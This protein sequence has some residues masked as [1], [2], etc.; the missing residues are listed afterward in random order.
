MPRRYKFTYSGLLLTALLLLI[1][2][3]SYLFSALK[4][5]EQ[6]L[7][8][9]E[10]ILN[11]V[12]SL[13]SG[14]AS[15]PDQE[16][17]DRTNELAKLA[18]E[19][20]ILR[21]AIVLSSVIGLRLAFEYF[22][23]SRFFFILSSTIARSFDTEPLEI[24]FNDR[25]PENPAASTQE[26]LTSES[27]QQSNVKRG[28][29]PSF[30]YG[31]FFETEAIHHSVYSRALTGQISVLEKERSTVSSRSWVNLL[32]GVSV[33]VVAITV[34]FATSSTLS[35]S[36]LPAENQTH[37]LIARVTLS[38]FLQAVAVFFLS[39]Y[40]NGLQEVKFYR[41][42][43]SNLASLRTAVMLADASKDADLLRIAGEKLVNTE[44]NFVLKKGET[45]AGML[46][47]SYEATIADPGKTAE[48]AVKGK[49]NG[50]GKPKQE[51]A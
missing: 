28:I 42:E 43:I 15:T 23:S 30:V 41:N 21:V 4:V 10:A 37:Y 38:F 26:G 48:T 2:L 1:V 49:A 13:L 34:L 8:A 51:Q 45:T 44:R 3:T 39:L 35:A 18:R 14:P 22:R 11:T 25:T 33:T 20:N 24:D 46:Q 16:I 31:S 5:K 17:R 27:S 7:A 6:D 12:N 32:L 29:R 47:H 40:R 50:Q 19:L 9:T 36:E